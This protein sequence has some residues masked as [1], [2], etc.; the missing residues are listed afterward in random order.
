MH[1]IRTMVRYDLDE[2]EAAEAEEEEGLPAVPVGRA[3][4]HRHP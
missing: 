2:E 1:Y 3:A 4:V